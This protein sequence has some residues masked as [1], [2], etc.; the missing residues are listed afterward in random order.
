MHYHPLKMMWRYH[1]V[2][3][4]F[5]FLSMLQQRVIRAGGPADP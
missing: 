2:A 3:L 4:A 1:C 5:V